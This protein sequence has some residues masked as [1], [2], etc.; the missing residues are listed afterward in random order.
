[1]SDKKY[2]CKQCDKSFEMR[3]L[4]KNHMNRK[5]PCKKID[6]PYKCKFCDHVFT[7]ETSLKRHIRD[8][9]K[10]LKELLNDENYSN[11]YLEKMVAIKN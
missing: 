8:N 9:C 11:I 4:L 5:F 3:Y 2:I 7:R 1:M 10:K 6:K